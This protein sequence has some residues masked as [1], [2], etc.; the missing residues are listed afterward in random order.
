MS[1]SL[2]ERLG[3]LLKELKGKIDGLSSCGIVAREGLIVA[4]ILDEGISEM[5]IA[6]MSAIILTTCERV[7]VELKRGELDICVVQGSDGKFIVMEC[8][9]ENILT[10]VFEE[11]VAM[12]QVFIQMRMTVNK[13]IEF[14]ELYDE[15][16][17]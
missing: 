8:G 14:L 3:F 10:G 6:A 2:D 15:E 17:D 4:S 7:L 12:D 11:D 9:D 5:H 16:M 1:A 13:V